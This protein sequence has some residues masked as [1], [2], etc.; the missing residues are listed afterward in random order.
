MFG[1]CWAHVER[2]LSTLGAKWPHAAHMLGMLGAPWA[3][4]G[5]MLG[6]LGAKWAQAEHMLGMLRASWCKM[7]AFGHMRGTSR[8]VVVKTHHAA[9]QDHFP[10]TEVHRA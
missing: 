1:A 6:T 5:R 10:H 4:N 9:Q 8:I 7:A 3:Q 2:M